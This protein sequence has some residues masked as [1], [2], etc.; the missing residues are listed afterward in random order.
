MHITAELVKSKVRLVVPAVTDSH[1]L[2]VGRANAVHGQVWLQ[3][4]QYTKY[5][6]EGP[7]VKLY[8]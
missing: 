7:S 6:D 5:D 8:F 1:Q 4:I 2:I 3:Y